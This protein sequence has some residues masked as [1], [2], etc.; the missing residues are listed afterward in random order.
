MKFSSRVLSWSGAAAA[1]A[2]A[3]A[4]AAVLL[5]RA[6]STINVDPDSLQGRTEAAIPELTGPAP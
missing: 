2:A 5:A 3:A 4:G 1:A 6:E